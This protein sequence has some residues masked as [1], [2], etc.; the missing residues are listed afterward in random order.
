MEKCLGNTYRK[1]FKGCQIKVELGEM[2]WYDSIY[3][4][5]KGEDLILLGVNVSLY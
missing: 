4:E 2:N 1:R 3:K 5:S